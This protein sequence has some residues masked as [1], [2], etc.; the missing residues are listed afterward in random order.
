[1]TNPGWSKSFPDSIVVCDLSGI[2]IEMNERAAEMYKA[3]GGKELVGKNLLECHP[4][5]ARSKM[6]TLLETGNRNIYTIEKNGIRKMIYQA[7]WYQDGQR[8]GMLELAFEIPSDMPHFIR[9]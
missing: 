5:P 9:E 7:P 3:Y 4:E 6:K 8:L 1:M 2:I